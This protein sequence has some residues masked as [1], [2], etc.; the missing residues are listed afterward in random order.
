MHDISAILSATQARQASLMTAFAAT[1]RL[2]LAVAPMIIDTDPG[3]GV[4]TLLRGLAKAT[5]MTEIAIDLCTFTAK[6]LES[7]PA[8]HQGEI[9][10]RAGDA[11]TVLERVLS[12]PRRALVVISVD[13]A[14]Q[15]T[16]EAF[17]GYVEKEA[18]VETIVAI[19]TRGDELAVARRAIHERLRIHHAH[20]PHVLVG[21]GRDQIVQLVGSLSMGLGKRMERH[22]ELSVA[23]PYDHEVRMTAYATPEQ[24]D[25]SLSDAVGRLL[26]ADQVAVL[27]YVRDGMLECSTDDMV[28]L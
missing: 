13:G 11:A 22:L 25:D 10:H 18:T 21:E 3:Y 1:M 7:Y 16:L 23:E 28:A 6:D 8:L 4:V 2:D 5:D 15:D 27:A 12:D 17:L 9:V 26:E 20:V 19:L 14:T 24:D